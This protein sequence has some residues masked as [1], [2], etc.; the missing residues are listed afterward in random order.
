MRDIQRSG[1]TGGDPSTPLK[2][3][4]PSL[5]RHEMAENPQRTGRALVRLEAWVGRSSVVC[6]IGVA[7]ATVGFFGVS[8]YMLHAGG[9]S[10]QIALF[11]AMVGGL[12]FVL[13]RLRGERA[14]APA[15]LTEAEK[16]QSQKMEAIGRLAGGVAHDFNN[17][18]AVVFGYSDL[19]L[20]N[21]YISHQR[22]GQ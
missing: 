9:R 12:A 17:L 16:L 5:H 1:W 2:A 11:V 15:V 4:C 21:L 8:S 20:E 18:L 19:L 13:D 14:G 6:A 7:L 3:G 22:R 10:E